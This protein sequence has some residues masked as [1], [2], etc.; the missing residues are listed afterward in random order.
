MSEANPTDFQVSGEVSQNQREIGPN[1]ARI[2][3]V[4]L[5]DQDTTRNSL[6]L[7]DIAQ[8]PWRASPF[9]DG[10]GTQT[11]VQV[12]D[13]NTH[14]N[15]VAQEVQTRFNEV[16]Q[17]FN[18]EVNS[19][20]ALIGRRISAMRDFFGTSTS[21]YAIN[22]RFDQEQ[23]KINRLQTLAT[24]GNHEEFRQA[25]RSL[26]GYE[27]E[28]PNNEQI[29]RRLSIESITAGYDESQRGWVNSISL[30]VP[31]IATGGRAVGPLSFLSRN[32]GSAMLAD[33]AVVSV[34]NYGLKA[35]DGRYSDPGYDLATGAVTGLLWAPAQRAS[36]YWTGRYM[37]TNRI[38]PIFPGP[39][40]TTYNIQ[41]QGIGALARESYL[42]HATPWA[43]YG[44]YEPIAREATDR[45]F[46]KV[47]SYDVG[48]VARN[49]L[50]GASTGLGSG[51]AFGMFNT[52]IMNVLRPHVQRLWH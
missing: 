21:A 35:M 11:G 20:G 36:T 42:R 1:F 51:Q 39:L 22:Q 6:N 7:V 37:S 34:G 50:W 16:R 5:P 23:V 24:Q 48:R 44:G 41:G 52:P 29:T 26:T 45:Y 32:T 30:I 13:Q 19:Q 9:R 31:F 25:Y 12:P 15:R 3:S 10:A 46:G 17:R 43:F 4:R 38:E 8:A 14:M 28:R 40:S 2:D 49:S 27:L 18:Q 33:A 47:D